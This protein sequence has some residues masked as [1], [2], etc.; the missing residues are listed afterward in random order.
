[1]S[2]NQFR[3][4]LVTGA[5]G[6]IGQA[7]ARQLAQNPQHQVVLVARDEAKARA[8]VGQI[9]QVT[10]NDLSELTTNWQNAAGWSG[11]NFNGDGR[12]TEADLLLLAANW[13]GKAAPVASVP[14]PSALLLLGAG[15]VLLLVARHWSTR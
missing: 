4:F 2:D 15:A 11:G 13:Q 5:T 9:Q 10:G 14:E 7:I 8:A 3:V 1:M 12:V 6:A